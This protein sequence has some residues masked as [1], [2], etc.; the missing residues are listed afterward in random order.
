MEKYSIVVEWDDMPM[1]FKSWLL[2]LRSSK[3]LKIRQFSDCDNIE[4]TGMGFDVEEDDYH[5]NPIY[6]EML[7]KFGNPKRKTQ[8][9]RWYILDHANEK[10]FLHKED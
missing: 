1:G 6:I 4:I 3:G 8:L 9:K 10:C 7:S 2:D 5:S